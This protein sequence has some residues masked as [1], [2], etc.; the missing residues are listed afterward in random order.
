M[1]RI[2]HLDARAL[3]ALALTVACAGC[4][5]DAPKPPTQADQLARELA[6]AQFNKASRSL[7]EARQALAPLVERDKPQLRDLVHAAVVELELAD[8]PRARALLERAAKLDPDDA[9]L[10]YNFGRLAELDADFER[11]AQSFRKALKAAPTDTPTKVHLASVIDEAEPA[12]AE[13]LLREVVNNGL[14]HEGAWYVSALYKLFRLVNADEARAAEAETLMNE[15]RDL[16]KRGFEAAKDG[17]YALGNLGRVTWPGPSG[18]APAPAGRELKLAAPATFAPELG[19]AKT[20]LARDLDND[21]KLDLVGFGPKGLAIALQRD[22]GA[23]ESRSLLAEPV[24]FAL[25]HDFANDDTVDF[26]VAQGAQLTHLRAKKGENGALEWTPL[27]AP[28]LPGAPASGLAFDLDHEGDLDLLFVGPFGS[29]AFRNDGAGKEGG[30][31]RDVTEAAGLPRS[32]AYEWCTIEDFDTDQDVDLLLGGAGGLAVFSNLRGGKFEPRPE[33]FAG[34]PASSKAHVV[35]DFDADARPDVWSAADG[36]SF[37]RRFDRSLKAG[38]AP[39]GLDGL[40][41]ARELFAL[42]LDLN[43]AL[44]VVWSSGGALHVRYD[45]GLPGERTGKLALAGADGAALVEDLDGDLAWDVAWPTD[46]GVSWQRG[47]IAGAKALRLAFRG[48]KDNR[49]G[50][51]AV[52]ELRAGPIYRRTYWRGEATLL[53]VGEQT[54]TDVV[55]VLWPNGVFQYELRRDLGDRAATG[56]GALSALEQQEGL[57]GSCP[58]LYTW[59]GR[60]YEFISDVLGITP[61]GLP[62]APGMLVPPDHDEFVLV[63]GEQLAPKDGVF[64]LH[65]TEELREVTYLDRVRLDVVD[66]PADVE[67]FPN[68]LFSFPPF[69]V[70]HTHTVRGALSPT[71]ALGSDGKDWT[72]Q[73]ARIDDDYAEPFE[74]APSQFLGLANP[75]WIE[76]EFDLE[77]V[78]AAKKLRLVATG[79][80]YWT[81]ASVNMASAYDP[82]HEFVPPMIQVQGADGEWKAAGPPIGFPAGK[83]KTMVVDVT[84]VLPRDTARIRLFGSLR[85][86]WDA[87][88]LAVDDDDA[89]LRTHSLEP[90]SA[91]LWPRGFSQPLAPSSRREPERFDWNVLAERPRWNQHPGLYTKFG[92]CLELVGAIDDRLVI[93]G[94]GDALTLRF[95]ATKLPPLEAGWRRDYLVFLDGWAKDRD[96]NTIDAL[97]VEPLP[98]HGM[99]GYPYGADERFPEGPEHRAWRREWNTRPGV[100]LIER[101]APND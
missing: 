68:E 72:K 90:Q 49:R 29:R 46:A 25:A 34:V 55:R 40:G 85:L 39:T 41:A 35:A 76:L 1:T 42:D 86:Y 15:Y 67:I 8:L 99:S 7:A 98:F 84:S 65:F 13:R 78:R 45:A 4:G 96:P 44:D 37:L 79:W 48:R 74:P 11:A 88:R 58:F 95:D 30:A 50:I 93:L 63:K 2:P 43:G 24:E 69:P 32:G 71:K 22:A 17:E 14:E 5:D 16:G 100:E 89:S 26:L 101:L 59:N 97:H 64:E 51:G 19:G 6:A 66:S 81:D 12:E 75:H 56:G 73:L 94:S 53:G 61:L 80:F 70:E 10:H 83:T 60:E 20:L 27:A 23:W 91:T 38:A 62:M 92:E 21:G 31:F 54:G 87:L 57:A 36:A 28:T 82:A 33:W 47:S 52:V 3:L 9:A 77:R 18:T